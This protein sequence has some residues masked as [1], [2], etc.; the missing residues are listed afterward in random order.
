MLVPNPN[1]I[2]QL[3]LD[4][5]RLNQI[6]IGLIHRSP[7][8]NDIFPKL[9]H[10]KCLTFIETNSG[11]HN[12]TLDKKSSYLTTF[13]YQFDR[14]RCTRLSFGAVSTGHIKQK[15]KMFKELVHEFDTAHDI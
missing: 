12:I 14:Y 1:E 4:P 15:D 13:A 10:G 7:T 9:M 6:L 3:C 2:I 11:Y 5:P 8:I